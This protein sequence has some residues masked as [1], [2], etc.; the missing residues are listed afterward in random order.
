MAVRMSL[1]AVGALILAYCLYLLAVKVS[2]TGTLIFAAIG[3]AFF[4]QGFWGQRLQLWLQQKTWRMRLWKMGLVVFIIWFATLMGFFALLQGSGEQKIG[5]PKPDVILV[6][7]SSTP[8]GK[9]SPALTE[10]LKL[11]YQLALQHPQAVVVVS[12]GVDFRQTVSEA[13]VMAGYLEAMGLPKN[14]ILLEDKSTS[15]QENLSFSGRVL[16]HIG[17]SESSPTVIVTSDFHTPRAARIALKVGW[18]QIRTVGAPTPL[19]MRY[20]AW[21]REYF[22]CIN[23]WLRNEF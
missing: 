4:F 5:L 13:Q 23:G 17:H 14:R 21:T 19:Y 6:L 9:P 11:A 18:R 20:P 3:L 10:R 2:H 1:V 16:K 15:T 12:G 7:G 22:A 8:K